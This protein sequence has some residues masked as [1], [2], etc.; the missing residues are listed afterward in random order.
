MDEQFR[1]LAP[2]Y[3]ALMAG[4]PY[5]R[6]VGDIL[7]RAT[8]YRPHRRT[9][10]DVG[11][12][13]GS[14]AFVMADRGLDVVG[15]DASA[16]MIAEARRKG[17]GRGNPRFLV[18]RMEA[19]DIPERFDLAASLFDTV[20]YVTNPADLQEAFHRIHRHLLP[21]GLWIFD[22]NTPFALEMELFTQNNLR[23]GAEPRYD[24]RSH[25]DRG[26]RLTT[27]D[28]TFYVKRG[29]RRVTMKE[30]HRQRAYALDEIR[31]MLESAGFEVLDIAE[32]YT[33]RP[34]EPDSDRAMF[35]TRRRTAP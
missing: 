27:V 29:N 5:R 30:T 17:E 18:S 19:L 4:I 3:D 13:T 1:G 21:G 14:A 9:V 8:R 33:G 31:A 35:V 23:T 16:E 25:Y 26:A 11:C 12:G 28:M 22:M 10:L 7:A 15:V 6:W 34:L 20:N 32:A 24:W 2:I